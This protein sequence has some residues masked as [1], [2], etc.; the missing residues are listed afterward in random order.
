LAGKE[1]GDE[2]VRKLAHLVRQREVLRQQ[3]VLIADAL[4][5]VG[6][7]IELLRAQATTAGVVLKQD[8]E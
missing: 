1:D 5:I 8:A 4:A 3:S 7:E 6:D 2:M